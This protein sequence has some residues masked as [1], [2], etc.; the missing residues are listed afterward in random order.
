M[1]NEAREHKSLCVNCPGNQYNV[2]S[3]L[4][5]SAQE[6]RFQKVPCLLSPK[7]LPTLLPGKGL[8]AALPSPGVRDM[9]SP[10]AE[11]ASPSS[12]SSQGTHI[13]DVTGPPPA[14]GPS[15]LSSEA[16]SSGKLSHQQQR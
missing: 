3:S 13:S 9:T 14:P 8:R 16:M 15:G 10:G 7:V 12:E 6:G 4:R 5:L 1:Q 2:P 11:P